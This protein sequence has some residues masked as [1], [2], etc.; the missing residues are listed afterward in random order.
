MGR[1]RT[2]TTTVPTYDTDDEYEALPDEFSIGVR[3][4]V[5]DLSAD[6]PSSESLGRIG[7]THG[8]AKGV[9]TAEC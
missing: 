9:E 6:L 5:G 8:T 4:F 1:G 2:R 3:Y 7:L